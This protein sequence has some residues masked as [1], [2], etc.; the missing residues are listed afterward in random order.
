MEVLRKTKQ[1]LDFDRCPVVGNPANDAIDR[2]LA[3]I[4]D[5]F[6]GQESPA[7]RRKV[8]LGHRQPVPK[9]LACIK[10]MPL[11]STSANFEGLGCTE[12]PVIWDIHGF[13]DGPGAARTVKKLRLMSENP[14]KWHFRTGKIDQSRAQKKA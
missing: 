5:D 12:T 3:E 14:E 10:P 2:R 13:L 11:S 1:A 4:G 7:A 9:K 6:S 8:W